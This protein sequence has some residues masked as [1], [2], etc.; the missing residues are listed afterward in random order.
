MYSAQY[1]SQLS[2]S[3]YV[4]SMMSRFGI[5][6]NY[7][8]M[9][10]LQAGPHSSAWN[11]CRFQTIESHL[12]KQPTKDDD[13]SVPWDADQSSEEGQAVFIDEPMTPNEE[14][15]SSSHADTNAHM[16]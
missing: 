15:L 16:N 6:N 12:G 10:R 4:R 13:Q 11:D 3:E 14:L 1:G 5:G 2:S 8:Q 9:A 7:S